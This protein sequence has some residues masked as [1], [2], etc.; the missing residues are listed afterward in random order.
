MK[1]E[2]SNGEIIDKLTILQIKL[3]R[4]KD[5]A[6]LKNLRREYDELSGVASPIM[7]DSD[8][9]YKALYKVN[10]ELWDIEDLI[11]SME[12]KKDFGDEFI[13]AARSVYFRN[14][15]RAEIKREINVRTSSGLTEEKSY[16]KY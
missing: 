15:K 11:R 1:I 7:K 8:P 3:E 16:E 9:L 5:E 10:C 2:V 6:K 14:D 4:I 12:R 13:S